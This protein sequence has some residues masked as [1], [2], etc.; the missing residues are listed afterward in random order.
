MNFLFTALIIYFLVSF[1]MMGSIWLD[2]KLGYDEVVEALDC[3]P[4]IEKNVSNP[5]LQETV[6]KCERTM[7]LFPEY[8]SVLDNDWPEPLPCYDTPALDY[9]LSELEQITVD[10]SLLQV[11]LEPVVDTI[12]Q[13][14]YD[15][16]QAKYDELLRETQSC[17]YTLEMDNKV[18]IIN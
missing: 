1:G 14:Q 18:D 12:W 11:D 8:F 7:K 5:T 13:D 6:E 3:T 9:C 15:K 10:L 4:I 16:V 2:K 17:R